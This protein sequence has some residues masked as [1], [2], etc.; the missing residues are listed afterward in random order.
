MKNILSHYH[1]EPKDREY[2]IYA[3]D[4]DGTL[5]VDGKIDM[6]FLEKLLEL[7]QQGNYI[8]LYTCR[9]MQALDEAIRLCEQHWL[10][11]DDICVKPYADHYIDDLNLAKETLL[12]PVPR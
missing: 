4:F 8:V 12:Q 11:F 1:P 5:Y 7:Q 3:V 2:R 6:P 10:T 9:T